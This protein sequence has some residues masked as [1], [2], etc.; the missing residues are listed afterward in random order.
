M[1]DALELARRRA[2]ARRR[3]MLMTGLDPAQSPAM[4][5]GLSDLSRLSRPEPPQPPE[6]MVY[7]PATQQYVDVGALAQMRDRGGVDAAIGGAMQGAGLRFGDEAL[8]GVGYVEGLA[9]GVDPGQMAT[10]RREEARAQLAQ[11]RADNPVSSVVGEI[12]GSIAL[13]ATAIRSGAGWLSN[14]ARSAIAGAGYG[15]VAAAG[16]GEGVEGRIANVP[17]GAALGAAGGA[18]AVPVSAAA[19]W[20]GRRFGP[21][22]ASVFRQRRYFRDG[23]LTPEGRSAV[24]AAGFDPDE[25]S[26]QF[27]RQFARIAADAANPEDAAR[28][29]SMAEFGIPAY[30]HNITGNV[31]DFATF[32]GA[33]RGALGAD[34]SQVVGDAA[35][36]Q[37]QAVRRAGETMATDISGGAVADQAD[38]AVA[39]QTGLRAARDRARSA[40][41]QAYDDL[42][43]AGG[44]IRGDALTGIDARLRRSL[45]MSEVR[46]DPTRTPN[47]A[48]ALD[49]VRTVFSRAREGS[50]PFTEIERVRQDLVR[51]R[52]A[53]F[54]GSV[55]QDQR[56]MTALVGAYD[57]A[58]EDLMTTSMIEG[59]EAVLRQAQRARQLWADYSQT[60]RGD[61]AASR[62]IQRMIDDDASPDDVARWLFSAGRL[63]SGQFNSTLARGIR[64]VLGDTSE[65]WNAI[66]QGAF[67]Q[68]ISRAEGTA[69]P[70][71]QQMAT[72]INRFLNDHT[73]RDLAAALFSS[74]EIATMR[75][76]AGALGRMVP[77][78]GSV[79]YSGTAYENARAVRR[80]FSAL[81][82]ALGF[83][84]TG[85][86][87][88]GGA[89]GAMLGGALQGAQGRAQVANVLSTA[90]PRP[91][92]V[93][94][95][96]VA[97]GAAQIAPTIEQRQNRPR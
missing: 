53:A 58:V 23:Q 66:R 91:V 80:A 88:G 64:D 77:P 63:G 20:A 75:R 5:Q 89:A 86:A 59:D 31:E 57:D 12:A 71:P 10:Y 56:A 78:P 73:S 45:E 93:P 60:F 25:M 32:E 46:I 40:A 49:Q 69:Q 38:A 72:A 94:V 90:T 26:A 15:A 68:L 82:G 50:V 22:V 84:A 44:G 55:G 37:M 52:S 16:E 7:N 29:A 76:F 70:G 28:A 27:Q 2:E 81:S 87:P 51:N 17:V 47:A 4:Q 33:R 48:D 83:A 34:A 43:N 41:G 14:V 6:G 8:G 97:V 11:D 24:A 96:P 65:Q 74:Q 35:E 9:R 92:S 13:P 1:D 18:L 54:R 36:R 3:Q 30:R 79:N 67:R 61:G 19:A 39:V 42:A 62:F 95:A 21:R 85:G